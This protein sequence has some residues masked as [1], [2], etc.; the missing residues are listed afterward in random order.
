MDMSTS[1]EN[2]MESNGEGNSQQKQK[3][4]HNW[5][6]SRWKM[7]ARRASPKGEA[8]KALPTLQLG[9]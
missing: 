1:L 3:R 6:V 5:Y 4:Q 7:L 8:R 9:L 2:E